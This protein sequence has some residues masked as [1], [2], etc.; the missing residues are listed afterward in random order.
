MISSEHLAKVSEAIKLARSTNS[1]IT[2]TAPTGTG[3]TQIIPPYLVKDVGTSGY[4]K[5][6]VAVPTKEAAKTNYL[7]VKKANPG[8]EVGFAA[9]GKTNY[10]KD[11]TMLIYATSGH[12][13]RL[14]YKEFHG[15]KPNSQTTYILIIDEYHTR[16]IDNDIILGLWR[17]MKDSNAN[18]PLLILASATK[19]YLK[20]FSNLS[21]DCVLNIKSP[22]TVTIVPLLS[23][24]RTNNKIYEAMVNIAVNNIKDKSHVLLFVPSI[25]AADDI[26]FLL[27][28]THKREAIS[29]HSRTSDEDERKIISPKQGTQLFIVATNVLETS[30]TIPGVGHVIDSLLEKVPEKSFNSGKKLVEKRITLTSSVQRRGRT[31]RTRNG[32]YHPI[33]TAEELSNLQL[34]R[35]PEYQRL[36]L[37]N[38]FLELL[39]IGV[40]PK[41]VFTNLSDKEV[42]NSYQYLIKHGAISPDRTRITSFGAFA[43]ATSLSIP[44]ARFLWE[45]HLRK[46][47]SYWGTVVCA[48]METDLSN[49]FYIP[50]EVKKDKTSLVYNKYVTDNFKQYY[51][52]DHLGVVLN[53]W[54]S[55]EESVGGLF[56]P[57][58]DTK[59]VKGWTKNKKINSD[60]LITITETILRVLSGLLRVDNLSVQIL[61]FRYLGIDIKKMPPISVVDLMSL[62]T[63][64]FLD[65]FSDR[66]LQPKGNSYVN[67][68][69]L[70]YIVSNSIPCRVDRKTNIIAIEEIELN[71]A[72]RKILIVHLYIYSLFDESKYTKVQTPLPLGL[73]LVP[74]L[75][76]PLTTRAI[77]EDNY[78]DFNDISPFDI[79][80]SSLSV[81]AAL[82][83]PFLLG[84]AI[85]LQENH[86][87]E[88]ISI[89]TVPLSLMFRKTPEKLIPTVPLIVKKTEIVKKIVAIPRAPKGS[90]N[91]QSSEDIMRAFELNRTPFI[92][93]EFKVTMKDSDVQNALDLYTFD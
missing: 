57:K 66:V 18:A 43:P 76:L 22:Y 70:E 34:E 28:N 92:L 74:I 63:P 81:P 86:T 91:T 8:I 36:F 83:I 47:A 77:V 65:I 52:P 64:I 21:V 41:D 80:F 19:S 49:L 20:G 24:V 75:T 85:L 60:V 89:L 6:I 48:I 5:V 55:F 13:K 51:A 88:D 16:T 69:G 67:S 40:N 54:L 25:Q 72:G 10:N 14:F 58:L 35:L 9:G 84:T 46:G 44:A 26:A 56:R 32:V 23:P 45:W 78:L 50:N 93:G 37:Y 90:N 30:I 11:T 79:G 31:G 15:G 33:A 71:N 38:E 73:A 62:S 12:I 2:I 4:I 7:S 17:R 53:L 87:L 39:H 3:K 42:E 27:K 82:R 68:K 29:F 1:I 61:E 59:G